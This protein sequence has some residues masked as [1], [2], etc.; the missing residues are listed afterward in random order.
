MGKLNTKRLEK[1]NTKRLGILFAKRNKSNLNLKKQVE[2]RKK[3]ICA[4]GAGETQR[5]KS[6]LDYIRYGDEFIVNV[7]GSYTFAKQIKEKIQIFLKDS[8]NIE[9]NLYKTKI[10]NPGK[11]RVYF[12]GY[13]IQATSFNFALN[14]YY[15]RILVPVKFLFNR[16]VV[17]KFY[18]L[19]K[20]RPIHIKEWTVLDHPM[21]IARYNTIIKGLINYYSICHGI[22]GL[23]KIL[24]ILRM[25]AITTLGVKLKLNS[26][27]VIKKFG[28]NIAY[29][30]DGELVDKLSLPD[31]KFLNKTNITK[32]KPGATPHPRLGLG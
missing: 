21:I 4:Y 6:T 28:L 15:I 30:N 18:D 3:L 16:L 5:I 23:A 29:I 11:E 20:K 12:L 32:L 22:Q 9:L 19:K 7:I 17:N 25:S 31:T 27:K 2:Y 26:F 1:L 24:Y 13:W 10:T 14:I 8:L